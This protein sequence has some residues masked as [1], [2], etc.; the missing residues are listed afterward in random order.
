MSVSSRFHISERNERHR[1]V[2]EDPRRKEVNGMK[3]KILPLLEER[4]L[5]SYLDWEMKIE[6][7]FKCFNFNE[8]MKVKVAT[9]EFN[10]YVLCGGI[11]NKTRAKNSKSTTPR[12][13]NKIKG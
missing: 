5:D 4:K 10:G 12:S 1:I 6:K 2:R 9:L 11:K 8:M 3:Y 13:P 7:I